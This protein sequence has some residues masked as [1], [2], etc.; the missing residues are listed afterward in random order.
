MG[1]SS[2]PLF[3]WLHLSDIHFGHGSATEREH[4]GLVLDQLLRDLRKAEDWGAPPPDAV[5][6]TGDI[7]FSGDALG[8]QEYPQASS[9]LRQL[10]GHLG[11]K[12]HDI[13]LV[14]GN[15]DVPRARQE[16]S[17]TLE[18]LH[19]LRTGKQRLDDVLDE[20]GARDVLAERMRRYRDLAIQLPS[21]C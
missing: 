7:G 21:E 1:S 5:L 17:R 14:P 3:S 6:V 20:A 8:R 10:A 9:W 18:L 13:Y 15:H 2:K 12:P 11:L 4:R 16:D 19:A